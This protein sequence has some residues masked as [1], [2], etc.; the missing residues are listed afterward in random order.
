[1]NVKK[2]SNDW[3]FLDLGGCEGDAHEAPYLEPLALY[4]CF[5]NVLNAIVKSIPTTLHSVLFGV[6][7]VD[8]EINIVFL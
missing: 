6:G 7:Y 3:I 8:S 4:V 5:S 2:I 1:M